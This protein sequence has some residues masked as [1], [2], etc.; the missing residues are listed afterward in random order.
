VY[1]DI[2][3]N[4][5]VLNKLADKKRIRSLTITSDSLSFCYSEDVRPLL[6]TKVYGV[7][8]NEKNITMGDKEHVTLIVMTKSVKIRQAARE[9]IGSFRRND[10]RIRRQLARKYWRRAN[11]RTDRFF[12]ELRIL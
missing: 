10:A 6:T 4:R 11:H 8:R 2:Q 5:Y 12:T 1:F 3:L 9:I 7:D